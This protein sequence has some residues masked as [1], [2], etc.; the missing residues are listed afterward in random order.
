MEVLKKLP[1][2]HGLPYDIIHI[3]T[4]DPTPSRTL[5]LLRPPFSIV[6]GFPRLGI[7]DNGQTIFPA[8]VIRNCLHFVIVLGST[9]VLDAVHKGNRIQHKMTM[10]MV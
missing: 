4:D 5:L 1:L 2:G 8:Q 10:K 3:R 9:V 6:L 7:F